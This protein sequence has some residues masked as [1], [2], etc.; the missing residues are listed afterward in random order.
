[1]AQSRNPDDNYCYNFEFTISTSTY[2]LSVYQTHDYNVGITHITGRKI[3]EDKKNL[4]HDCPKSILKWFLA[5]IWY[6]LAA[7]PVRRNTI[8]TSKT[9]L[10]LVTNEIP[11]AWGS[12]TIIY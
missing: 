2:L 11:N 4:R 7:K 1:M 10:S 3:Y 5:Q 12:G 9:I 8:Y 6:G